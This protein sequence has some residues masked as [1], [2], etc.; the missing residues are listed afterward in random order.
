MNVHSEN[1]H[2]TVF[3]IANT[4]FDISLKLFSRMGV[5]D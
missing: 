2:V 5:I 1:T 3:Y 4:D